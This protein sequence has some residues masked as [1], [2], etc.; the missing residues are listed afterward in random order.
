M[1]VPFSRTALHDRP[2]EKPT[3]GRHSQERAHGG[4]PGGL[5]ED[6]HVVRVPAERRD[7]PLNPTQRL[8]HIQQRNIGR[9]R[10]LVAQQPTQVQKA[11]GTQ[12]V[13]DGHHYRAAGTR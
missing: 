7:V 8:Q 5:T 6:C 4:S 13:V 3:G 10:V 11:Q 9:V 1:P 12:P 2:L